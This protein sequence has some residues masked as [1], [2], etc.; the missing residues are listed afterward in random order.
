MANIGKHKLKRILQIIVC[1]LSSLPSVSSNWGAPGREGK[2][3]SF[4][5]KKRDSYHFS[6]LQKNGGPTTFLVLKR[7]RAQIPI[8]FS[9]QGIRV[10]R[11]KN[12]NIHELWVVSSVA[13]SWLCFPHEPKK[14]F[15][16]CEGPRLHQGEM[17]ADLWVAFRSGKWL[18]GRQTGKYIW[19]VCDHKKTNYSTSYLHTYTYINAG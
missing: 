2:H 1:G 17:T 16:F 3:F 10:S 14:M 6:F 15:L 7:N 19:S 4:L 11:Y 8:F 13:F 9:G 12:A 5:Q 18:A